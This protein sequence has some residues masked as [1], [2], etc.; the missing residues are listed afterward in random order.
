MSSTEIMFLRAWF[1]ARFVRTERGAGLVEYVLLVTGIA[2]LVI[3]AVS[4]FGGR[5]RDKWSATGSSLP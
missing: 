4:F 2:C 5:V 3:L 1:E